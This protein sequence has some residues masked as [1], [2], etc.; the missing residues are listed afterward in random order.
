MFN[1]T[2]ISSSAPTVN[3]DFS[4]GYRPGIFW[5]NTS[6]GLFY[7]CEDDAEG[8]ASWSVTGGTSILTWSDWTPSFSWTGNSP[9]VDPT[10]VAR[11]ILSGNICYFTLQISA[12]NQAGA[13][14]TAVTIGLPATAA[15]ADTNSNIPIDSFLLD[16]G[17]YTIKTEQAKIES[18]SDPAVFNHSGLG[19]AAS[20]A[21]ELYYYGE[22]ETT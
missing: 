9:L 15:I 19:I 17:S 4:A 3:D 6:T 7:V 2:H 11:F 5:F 1:P 13:A 10:V 8:S 12:T 21:F 22:Y 20:H 16:N 14:I 18:V